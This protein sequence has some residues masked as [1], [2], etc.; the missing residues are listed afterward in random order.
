MSDLNGRGVLNVR[1]L[2]D[3]RTKLRKAERI[4]NIRQVSE[5]AI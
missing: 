1:I 2:G 5:K 3:S 4:S